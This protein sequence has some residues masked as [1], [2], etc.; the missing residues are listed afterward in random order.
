MELKLERYNYIVKELSG[1]VLALRIR[2]TGIECDHRKL[3]CLVDDYGNAL[4][5]ERLGETVG[6]AEIND[7]KKFEDRILKY[8]EN[9]NTRLSHTEK[10]EVF[11]E[12]LQIARE[13]QDFNERFI[14]LQAEVE[15]NREGFSNEFKRLEG[16][17]IADYKNVHCRIDKVIE[18]LKESHSTY[19]K[20]TGESGAMPINE[21]KIEK[22][23]VTDSV[24]KIREVLR[25]LQD[26]YEK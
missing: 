2:M 14:T 1:T 9:F 8:I 12:Q 25:I 7:Y 6:S 17:F 15:S 21:L 18:S 5:E 11:L 22:E 24:F 13:A 10:V 16:N 26:G 4:L 3:K 23:S 20:E 19:P